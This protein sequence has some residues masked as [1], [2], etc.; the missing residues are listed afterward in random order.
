M[1][2][3][4]IA[5]LLTFALL[6]SLFPSMITTAQAKTT[7]EASVPAEASP[8]AQPAELRGI[9]GDVPVTIVD[10]ATG[11]FPLHGTVDLP[12][13]DHYQGAQYP[14]YVNRGDTVTVTVTPDE[15]YYIAY[16]RVTYKR[17]EAGSDLAIDLDETNSF[18]LPTRGVYSVTVHATFASVYTGYGITVNVF[19]GGTGN[20]VTAD[21]ERAEEGET[22]NLTVSMNPDTQ[23]SAPG[24][25]VHREGDPS[26]TVELTQHSESSYSFVMPAFDVHVFAIFEAVVPELCE[27]RFEKGHE[28][29]YG[30]METEYVEPDVYYLVPYCGFE[31]P[32]GCGF[33]AW[34]VVVGDADPV[35]KKPGSEVFI[36]A[37]TVFTATY[38]MRYNIFTEP[39]GDFGEWRDMQEEA[40]EGNILDQ[41]Y[42]CMPRS[43]WREG[44]RLEKIVIEDYYGNVTEH[45]TNRDGEALRSFV[46]PEFGYNRYYVDLPVIVMPACSITVSAVFTR[47]EGYY[48]IGPDWNIASIDAADKFELNPYNAHEFLLHTTLAEG[49][50]IKVA[51]VANGVIDAW[52]PDGLD[53]QY[54]VDGNHAGDVTV[55]FST[56]Y[57]NDWSEFGGYFWIPNNG[58]YGISLTV[59]DG[60][61]GNTVTVDKEWAEA[62]ETVNLTVSMNPDTVFG[63]PGLVVHREGD[64]S[65]TVELIQNSE[66]SYS[67]VMPAFD[68][69]VSANFAFYVPEI[70]EIRFEKGD[71]LASGTMET[72][73]VEEGTEYLVPYCGFVAPPGC[74]FDAWS[75]VVG[76]ADPVLLKPGKYICITADTVF[77]ATYSLRYPIYT[78]P[79]GDFGEW[80]DMQEEA[81]EGNILDRY[82]IQMPKGLWYDGWRLEK[83]VVE[84]EYG[85][86]TEL[87]TNPGGVELHSLVPP[88]IGPNRYYTYL[89]EIIMPACS[90]TVSAVFTRIEGYYLIGPDWNIASIDAADKFEL[91]PYNAH[92]FLLHTTLAEGD[93]IKVAHVANGVIDAWYPDGLDNQYVVDGNHAGD[94][95]VYFSTEYRNDW[96]EFGGYFWIPDPSEPPVPM[97]TE[98]LHIYNSISVGT[99]MVITF[100]AR[101]NDLTDYNNFWI[102]VVKH[103]P[104]GD[105]TY[106]YN[107]DVMT[108]GSSTWAVQ[109]RN[110]YA[111]EM[112]ID[113]EARLYAENAAGQVY[114][115]PAKNANIRDYLGGRLT[116]TN[117]KV[118]QRVLAADMLNYGAAAQMFTGFQTDHLVNEELTADQLAKLH[119][120]ETSVP[121]PVNKT[122]YNTRP[123]GQPNIL[124]TSVTLG[125]EVLLNLTIRLTEGTEGVQVLVK[126]HETGDIVTTLDTAFLGSTFNAV[127]NGIGADAMRTEYDLVTVV[128]GVET[129]N[130]RTWSVE[131]YVGEIRAEGIPLKVAM[132]NALLAYGDSAAAY[133][134]AQ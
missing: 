105:V 128:N 74:G 29:A 133:F 99:D 53:N 113:V 116:A 71:E 102:E 24:L 67:F 20:T 30:T 4:L 18:T 10:D 49:D 91:N 38:S 97:E 57:R 6:C 117:N 93:Q 31:S 54:V 70:F 45:T 83:I 60:E 129:G 52:Y 40:G 101:K 104:D 43:L 123:A 118:Q 100:T 64:P 131:A 22:V 119:Q 39:L 59:D 62:G 122:N 47:I 16:F 109:F 106:T 80:R 115:S 114:R 61:T 75:I 35:L 44:W 111:K 21:K 69:H 84:N 12:G 50:Q 1:K 98:A 23:F 107:P 65:T 9:T 56:E 37:D 27:V 125:N 63:E 19:D 55:Y 42:I 26:T 14:Y 13:Y 17:T 25:S 95:T 92:E 66:S 68:V 28:L 96:S 130:I 15:D 85:N 132:A 78:V 79:L 11:A 34:S 46:A 103:N 120:Y 127:F 48:L 108:E 8:A 87:T 58:T 110:I 77:T 124:F 81:D 86:V 72:I 7:V 5:W 36:T 126:N 94:V 2:R 32:P 3:N 41:Y 51:H 89:P 33:D 76:D 112:G 121:A 88:E 90:I 134:A 82:Y 73:T